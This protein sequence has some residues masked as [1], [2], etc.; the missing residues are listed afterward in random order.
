MKLTRACA[1]SVS[2]DADGGMGRWEGDAPGDRSCFPRGRPWRSR[3]WPAGGRPRGQR[4]RRGPSRPR[5]ERSA[6]SRSTRLP[7]R[8]HRAHQAARVEGNLPPRTKPASSRA[9]AQAS[10][11]S[12]AGASEERND[13]GWLKDDWV[14]WPLSD[15]SERWATG[16]LQG[17][18]HG[19]RGVGLELGEA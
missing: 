17:W 18:R 6:L 7:H 9:T 2:G 16:G 11:S 4:R 8:H 3:S 19:R 1:G 13:G 14:P 10:T 5:R 15:P 12:L